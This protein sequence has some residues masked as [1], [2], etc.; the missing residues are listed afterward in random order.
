[1]GVDR[2][3]SV[4][5][6]ARAGAAADR[7]VI[8]MACIA[9]GE[10]VHRALRGRQHA[11]RAEQRIHDGLARLDIAAGDSG[12]RTRAQQRTVGHD[13]VERPQ[14]P[15]IHRDVAVD[16]AAENIEHGGFGDGARRIEIVR[17]LRARAG[18]IDHGA[19]ARRA[20]HRDLHA[21]DRRR[22]PS[23][24]RIRRP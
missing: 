6:V 14:T 16:E 21:D 13:D 11:Q 23:P 5:A 8:L 7:F 22:R 2:G 10:I 4:E 3:L 17:L 24:F 15:G 18:E 12:R 19:D 9:E 20:I 1:M